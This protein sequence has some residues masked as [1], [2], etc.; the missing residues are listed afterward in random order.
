MEPATDKQIS[1]INRLHVYDR[2]CDT[3]VPLYKDKAS[4]I[5][6]YLLQKKK[7]PEWDINK[8]QHGKQIRRRNKTEDRVPGRLG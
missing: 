3:P 4:E 2:K 5:I 6:R 1:Y 8:N 7:E